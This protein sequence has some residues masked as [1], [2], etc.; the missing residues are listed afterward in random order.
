[1]KRTCSSACRS[2]GNRSNPSS[3]NRVYRPKQ[4]QARSGELRGRRLTRLFNLPRQRVVGLP[5]P[6]H[7]GHTFYVVRCSARVLNRS[8]TTVV[9]STSIDCHNRLACRCACDW[10]GHPSFLLCIGR[11]CSCPQV[12][13]CPEESSVMAF[14]REGQKMGKSLGMF[15]TPKTINTV[16]P[17]RCAG[18]AAISNSVKTAI[19]NNNALDLVNNDLAN[20]IGNLLNRTS[21]MSRKW[22]DDSLPVDVDA[23]R[24]THVLRDKAEQTTAVVRDS[25]RDLAFQKPARPYSSWPSTPMVFSMNRLLGAVWQPGQEQQVGETRGPRMR[26]ISSG[27]FSNPLFLI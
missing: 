7:P 4:S 8:L 9:P 12:C 2:F 21:S 25:I 19:S 24:S 5:V 27:R 20:T 17:M 10:K 13:P 23:V 3:L 14:T 15:S 6:G 26:H 1:M 16:A 11:Q 18:I 22:F